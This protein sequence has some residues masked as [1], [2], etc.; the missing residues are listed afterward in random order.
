MLLEDLLS[1]FERELTFPIEL[2]AVLEQIGDLQVEGPVPEAEETIAGILEP[3]GPETFESPMVL[4]EAI[5]GNVNDA[6]IGRKYY[7]DR[8]GNPMG[9]DG[10]PENEDGV[11]L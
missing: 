5:Y 4:Y 10:R 1:H 2:A 6:H 11:S 7:D 3:L 8:G 9:Y